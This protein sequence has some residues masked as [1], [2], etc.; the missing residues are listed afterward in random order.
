MYFRSLNKIL[1]SLA[2]ILNIIMFEFQIQTLFF[3]SN[4]AVGHLSCNSKSYIQVYSTKFTFVKIMWRWNF[5][6]IIRFFK[7]VWTPL[8]FKPNSNVDYF[9]IFYSNSV[10][11]L[12]SYPKGKLFLL[13][14]S[15]ARQSLEICETLEVP[16][17]YFEA[18]INWMQLG[19]TLNIKKDLPG[20]AHCSVRSSSILKPA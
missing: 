3:Y 16:F 19:N 4:Q 11:D 6:E 5:R 1:I 14:L 17:L 7:K 13:N 15:T 9:L 12:K 2:C 10:V 20:P 8:K 18:R